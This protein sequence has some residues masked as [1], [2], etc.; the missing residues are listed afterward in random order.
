IGRRLEAAYP[1][2]NA[3]TAVTVVPLEEVLVGDLRLPLLVLLGAVGLVLLIAC[4]NVANLLLAR[5]AARET[6]FAVRSAIGAGRG[7]LTRQLLTESLLL[8]MAGGAVGLA[9]AAWGTRVLLALAPSDLPRLGDVAL[10]LDVVLFT[11]V[12]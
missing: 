8:A 4:A 1:E 2:A 3:R 5:A 10:D 9:L 6:E 7:R 12:I 11:A